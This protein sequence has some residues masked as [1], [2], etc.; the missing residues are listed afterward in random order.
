MVSEPKVKTIVNTLS[1]DAE[2]H[3]LNVADDLMRDIIIVALDTGLRLSEV[4]GLTGSHVTGD[5]LVLQAEDTKSGN[6]RVG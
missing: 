4:I 1:A 3:L 2:R 5:A 6:A